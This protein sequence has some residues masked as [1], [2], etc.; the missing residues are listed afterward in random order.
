MSHLAWRG[1]WADVESQRRQERGR[2]ME[3]DGT[4]A[5]VTGAAGPSAARARASSGSDPEALSVA[6]RAARHLRSQ[7]PCVYSQLMWS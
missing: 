1:V 6:C 4:P 3:F 5:R 7:T 2:G